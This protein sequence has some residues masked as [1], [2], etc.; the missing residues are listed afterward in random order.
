MNSRFQL[1]HIDV[2]RQ[3]PQRK[4]EG[5]SIGYKKNVQQTTPH[6]MLRGN[7]RSWP[8]SSSEPIKQ[9]YSKSVNML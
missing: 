7:V 1:Y 9:V 5:Q 4:F 8:I 3:V 2:G 6:H